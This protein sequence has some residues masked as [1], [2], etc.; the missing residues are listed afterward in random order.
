MVARRARGEALQL[1][2][3][4]RFNAAAR[5]MKRH[6]A[7]VSDLRS[8]RVLCAHGDVDT[9]GVSGS[10]AGRGYGVSRSGGG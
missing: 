2:N 5:P 9:V 6:A 8:F 10:L 1:R 4:R 7:W 3:S